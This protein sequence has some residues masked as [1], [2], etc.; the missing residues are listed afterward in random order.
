MPVFLT[1]RHRAVCP[2]SPPKEGVKLKGDILPHGLGVVVPLSIPSVKARIPLQVGPH[3]LSSLKA[4]WKGTSRSLQSHG[5]TPSE[6]MPR[7]GLSVFRG[8]WGADLD[9]QDPKMFELAKQ[10]LIA[11]TQGAQEAQP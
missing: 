5:K 8:I 4:F 1:P 6:T 3:F 11:K 10:I 7:M 9:S 2:R